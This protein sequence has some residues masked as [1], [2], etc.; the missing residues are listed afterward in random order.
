V[1]DAN[2]LPTR[3]EQM[4]E[5]ERRKADYDRAY[6]FWSQNGRVGDPPPRPVKPHTPGFNPP[7]NL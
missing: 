1:S 7:V 4:A 3:E 5:Y 2:R 6:A